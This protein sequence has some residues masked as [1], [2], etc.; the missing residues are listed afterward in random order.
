MQHLRTPR[1][2]DPTKIVRSVMVGVAKLFLAD[3]MRGSQ[4]GQ[5]NQKESPLW[6]S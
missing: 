4:E 2:D 6:E 5:E 1:L 3:C